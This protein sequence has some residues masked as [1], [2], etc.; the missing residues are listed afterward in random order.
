[1]GS[2]AYQG[3]GRGWILMPLI[4]INHFA[5]DGLKPDLTL[6]FVYPRWKGL[7]RIALIVT[8]KIN[9]LNLRGAWTCTVKSFYRWTKKRKCVIQ[10]DAD[11][12]GKL[13]NLAKAVLFDQNGLG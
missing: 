12:L 9:R 11:M 3:F 4:E 1:M 5:T 8:A 2:V 13:W 6:Y 10:V 7:A